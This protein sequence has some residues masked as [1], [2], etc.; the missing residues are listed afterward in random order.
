MPKPGKMALKIQTNLMRKDAI[1]TVL[2]D[3]QF[4]TDSIVT[5]AT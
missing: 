1:F 2:L 4:T 3:E 5:I